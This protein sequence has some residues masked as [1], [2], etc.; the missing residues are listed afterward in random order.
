MVKIGC[1][2][3]PGEV[4]KLVLKAKQWIKEKTGVVELDFT[5]ELKTVH[6]VLNGIEQL[7]V[8]GTELLLGKIFTEIGFDKIKDELFRKLVIARLCFPASKLATT[9][10]PLPRMEENMLV[11][12]IEKQLRPPMPFS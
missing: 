10:I 1:S 9:P 12:S 3:K 8:H 4:E 5:N 7:T 6:Q 11:I 2:I